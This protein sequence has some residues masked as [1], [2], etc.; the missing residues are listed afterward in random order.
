MSL[1]QCPPACLPNNFSDHVG[2]QSPLSHT[3]CVHALRRPRPDA[4]TAPLD[5]GPF[6]CGL[7]PS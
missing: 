3:W 1:A 6:C 2:N 5:G 7:L 4:G